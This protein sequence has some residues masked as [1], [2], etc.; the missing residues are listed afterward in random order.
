M[1][2]GDNSCAMSVDLVTLLPDVWLAHSLVFCCSDQ[3]NKKLKTKKNWQETIQ[4]M[5]INCGSWFKA[6]A[7]DG[8]GG[9]VQET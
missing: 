1:G 5:N 9:T 3:K 6:P 7:C 8:M 2:G 4:R